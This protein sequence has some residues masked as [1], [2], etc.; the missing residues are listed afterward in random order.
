MMLNIFKDL[1]NSVQQGEGIVDSAEWLRIYVI[2][3]ELLRNRG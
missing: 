2:Q 1:S 3:F